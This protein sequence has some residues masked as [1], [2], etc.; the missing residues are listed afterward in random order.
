MHN[1]ST[2]AHAHV[3]IVSILHCHSRH[4][5]KVT[6]YARGYAWSRMCLAKQLHPHPAST[7]RKIGLL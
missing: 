4:L 3:Q 5:L 7:D 1:K 6:S 2:E